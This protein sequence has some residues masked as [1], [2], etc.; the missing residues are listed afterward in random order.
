MA[1]FP[2]KYAP[3]RKRLPGDKFYV[4]KSEH[5]ANQVIIWGAILFLTFFISKLF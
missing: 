1:I 5:I 4:S 3:K 2:R